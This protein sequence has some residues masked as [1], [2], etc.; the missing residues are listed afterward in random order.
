MTTPLQD[1]CPICKENDEIGARLPCTHQMCLS[2]QRKWLRQCNILNKPYT[3]PFCM[4]II[5]PINPGYSTENE[6]L[7]IINLQEI[8]DPFITDVEYN[9]SSVSG[10]YSPSNSNSNSNFLWIVSLI[11]SHWKDILMYFFTIF[12][13][14]LLFGKWWL[15]ICIIIYACI[16][17]I[18]LIMEEQ[19][20]RHLYKYT[21]NGMLSSTREPPRPHLKFFNI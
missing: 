9:F 12:F 1:P 6:E 13:F 17:M 10:V 20:R 14:V 5:R 19:H 16:Y 18:N 15:T 3:C 21:L 2:C 11:H 4:C 7:Q 8:I